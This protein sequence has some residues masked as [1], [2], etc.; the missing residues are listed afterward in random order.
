MDGVRVAGPALTAEVAAPILK[1]VLERLEFL[2]VLRDHGARRVGA[3]SALI[4]PAP[5]PAIEM[6]PT[7]VP[8]DG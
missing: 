7:P 1:E 2:R 4:M 8:G 6:P 3:P 5:P